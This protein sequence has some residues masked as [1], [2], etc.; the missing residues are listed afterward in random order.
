MAVAGN[1]AAAK[2]ADITIVV[3]IA[4][5]FLNIAIPPNLTL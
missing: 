3:S 4:V 2:V 5:S 1:A